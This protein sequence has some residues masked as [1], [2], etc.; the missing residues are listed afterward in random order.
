MT[1][2]EAAPDVYDG[3]WK[4]KRDTRKCEITVEL[5]KEG[6]EAK[7]IR[8][9]QGYCQNVSKV[10]V[11]QAYG[12]RCF[13]EESVP[14]YLE[15]LEN[16]GVHFDSVDNYY[17][18]AVANPCCWS[19]P[20]HHEYSGEDGNRPNGRKAN[21]KRVP[22]NASS[23]EEEFF[24]DLFKVTRSGAC[25]D[26]SLLSARDQLSIVQ[27][28]LTT[29]AKGRNTPSLDLIDF[30]YQD[31]FLHL[32]EDLDD[33]EQVKEYFQ[34]LKKALKG[35]NLNE[36]RL[37]ILLAQY[38][39]TIT[40]MGG[41]LAE[42]NLFARSFLE[43]YHSTV[44]QGK[45]GSDLF[46]SDLDGQPDSEDLVLDIYR[47]DKT[48]RTT[49]W[50]PG[51]ALFQPTFH[52]QIEDVSSTEDQVPLEMFKLFDQLDSSSG[53]KEGEAL[54]KAFSRE[55]AYHSDRTIAGFI[56]N[57]LIPFL[58][59]D[60]NKE[61]EAPLLKIIEQEHKRWSS[62]LFYWVDF[63][64]GLMDLDNHIA[65]QH[66]ETL[67]RL[68]DRAVSRYFRNNT[69]KLITELITDTGG[70]QEAGITQRLKLLERL[71]SSNIVYI[72][73]EA[74]AIKA[75]ASLGASLFRQ[76]KEIWNRV[77]SVSLQY[78]RRFPSNLEMDLFD[79]IEDKDLF[80]PLSQNE[81]WGSFFESRLTYEAKNSIYFKDPDYRSI[82]TNILLEGDQL[83][84]YYAL[85]LLKSIATRSTFNDIVREAKKV[86]R[87][88]I[89]NSYIDKSL[90]RADPKKQLKLI[91]KSTREI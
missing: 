73:K 22:K 61:I 10:K 75:L 86:S 9:N 84:V 13:A 91:K 78:Y 26:L 48:F 16:D 76:D 64:L 28:V 37:T 27:K 65:P 55:R 33:A 29:P 41:E 83:Q 35:K 74:E 56:I 4:L 25:Y 69:Q 79:I 52:G 90:P 88:R 38:Y 62:E 23:Y 43:F 71:V 20:T 67:K 36:Q 24:P 15:S 81:E 14:G 42:D 58:K 89:K 6:G 3:G 49:L 8:N 18:P 31:K 7:V 70:D 72:P 87:I 53:V 21:S 51:A 66:Q 46:D 77:L 57:S 19:K 30:T 47:A 80:A 34:A 44:P 45:I 82:F 85:K 68:F 39:S 17:D 54:Y 63:P 32:P 59:A 40:Y 5:P 60:H 12:E 50:Q 1:R 2:V 11:V